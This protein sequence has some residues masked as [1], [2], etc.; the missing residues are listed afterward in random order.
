VGAAWTARF[1]DNAAQVDA[2]SITGEEKAAETLQVLGLSTKLNSFA[3][4]SRPSLH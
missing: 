1:A 3:L 2:L 4:A